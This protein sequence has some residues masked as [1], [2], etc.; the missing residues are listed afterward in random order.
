MSAL[1]EAIRGAYRGRKALERDQLLEKNL[2]D[3]IRIGQDRR[4]V[5]TSDWPDYF[6]P[7]P[8]EREEIS[9]EEE[10]QLIANMRGRNSRPGDLGPTGR[11]RRVDTIEQKMYEDFWSSGDPEKMRQAAKWYMQTD[12]EI[13]DK[14]RE[15]TRNR[16]REETDPLEYRAG[17]Y[18][19]SGDRIGPA[20]RRGSVNGGRA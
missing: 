18:S 5:D 7:L 17:L 13:P 14:G 2:A 9:P 15:K 4:Y 16:K 20:P 12:G 19:A 3:R 10:E 11:R 1:G 8:E 6:E